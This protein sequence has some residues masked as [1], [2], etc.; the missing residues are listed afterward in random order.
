MRF[1]LSSKLIFETNAAALSLS[2]KILFYLSNNQWPQSF[3]FVGIHGLH[4]TIIFRVTIYQSLCEASLTSSA[5]H[6][7]LKSAGS[8]EKWT[9]TASLAEHENAI[10]YS[11]R[12]W[13]THVDGQNGRTEGQTFP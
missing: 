8:N 4:Q 7:C 6:V 2:R 1:S 3:D 11:G 12:T 9:Q 13:P 5:G 10:R